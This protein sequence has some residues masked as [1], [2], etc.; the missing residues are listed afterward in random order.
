MKKLLLLTAFIIS[1]STFG[2]EA[3]FDFND[4][5][6]ISSLKL[7]KKFCFEEGFTKVSDKDSYLAMY[8]YGY[9]SKKETA[10][11]WAGYYII[12]KTFI[13][14]L[15]KYVNGSSGKS[16]EAI[17]NQVKKQCK[18]NDF[19]KNDFGDEYICYTCPNSSFKGKIGF[20]RGEKSDYI[21]TFNF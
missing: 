14:I 13:F 10:P 16:F 6:N 4:I 18:F 8:A 7:F 2:Q 21:K 11:I 12:S 20:R 15:N 9:N 5:K 17:L 3:D 19:Y 1:F